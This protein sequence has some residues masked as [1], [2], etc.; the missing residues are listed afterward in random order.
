MIDTNIY[1]LRFNVLNPPYKAVKNL[2][3][4][5]DE[6]GTGK[7]MG[8]VVQKVETDSIAITDHSLLLFWRIPYDDVILPP[9][10]LGFFVGGGINTVEVGF[11]IGAF[12]PFG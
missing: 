6:V 4:W 5:I 12:S 11:K 10:K 3:L 1:V 8:N 7:D 9:M 2:L